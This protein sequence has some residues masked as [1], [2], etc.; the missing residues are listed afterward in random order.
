MSRVFEAL[1]RSQG[2]SQIPI[3]RLW[4]RSVGSCLCSSASKPHRSR[5]V[6]TRADDRIGLAERARRSRS[7]SRA[8]AGAAPGGHDR[9][10]QPRRRNVPRAGHASGSHAAEAP[11]AEAADHQFGGGRRQVGGRRESGADPGAACRREGSADRSR[12]APAYGERA[13]LDD[14]AARHHRVERRQAGAGGFAVPDPRPAR[15][16]TGRRPCHG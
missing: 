1:Q 10:R 6:G 3:T 14:P 4:F 16:A 13:V 7:A 11:L 9:S 5:N 12:S 8:H 2:G 15:V